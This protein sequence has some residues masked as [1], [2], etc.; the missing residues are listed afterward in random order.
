VENLKVFM[1]FGALMEQEVRGLLAK[2]PNDL[3]IIAY[4]PLDACFEKY[5]LIDH[6]HFRAYKYAVSDF[7]GEGILQVGITGIQSTMVPYSAEKAFRKDGSPE[8]SGETQKINVVSAESVLLQ[9]PEIDRLDINV[10]GSEIPILMNTPLALLAR[11]KMI[12]VEFHIFA[13]WFEM[14]QEQVDKCV[15]RLSSCF[16]V[17]I[18][19]SYHP[20]YSFYRKQ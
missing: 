13:K 6:P 5:S 8:Y 20:C 11:C 9:Y 15:E 2:F 7:T 10:E 18:N 19:D 14:T 12:H 16:N 3:L 17:T 4:D 1:S